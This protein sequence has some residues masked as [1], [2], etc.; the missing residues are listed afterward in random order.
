VIYNSDGNCYACRY[1]N[2]SLGKR[3]RRSSTARW[4]VST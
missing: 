3:F 4:A 2:Q 1:G